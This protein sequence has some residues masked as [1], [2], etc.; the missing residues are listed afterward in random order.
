MTAD[1]IVQRA[2]VPAATQEVF[3]PKLTRP[4]GPVVRN[5]SSRRPPRREVLCPRPPTTTST[6]LSQNLQQTMSPKPLVISV[7]SIV[8]VL[9][10]NVLDFLGAGP[11]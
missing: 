2:N 9:T 6:T 5:F 7:L 8:G 10:W 1:D 3:R 4:P 11:A